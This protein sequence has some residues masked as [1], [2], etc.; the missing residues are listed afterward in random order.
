MTMTPPQPTL[1]LTSLQKL[2]VVYS[3]VLHHNDGTQLDGGFANNKL[4]QAFWREIVAL[5]PQ[6]YDV[7]VGRVSRIFIDMLAEELE[8]VEGRQLNV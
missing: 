6:P 5:P 2:E 7:P 1:P 4:S 3:T 8:G